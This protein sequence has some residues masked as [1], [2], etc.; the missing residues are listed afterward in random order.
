MRSTKHQSTTV[1]QSI[2]KRIANMRYDHC[3]QREKFRR[4]VSLIY[5]FVPTLVT[6]LSDRDTNY[7]GFKLFESV[8]YESREK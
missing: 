1:R 4:S 7:F 3:G 6:V 5:G 2:D 8:K